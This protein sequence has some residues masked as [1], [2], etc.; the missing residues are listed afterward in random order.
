M[1]ETDVPREKRSKSRERDRIGG[2]ARRELRRNP[3]ENG[4][5]VPGGL[6]RVLDARSSGHFAQAVLRLCV[7]P[8]TAL[9][10]RGDDAE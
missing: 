6:F 9:R 4:D 1:A 2:I 3:R 5:P 7:I 10:L 8:R